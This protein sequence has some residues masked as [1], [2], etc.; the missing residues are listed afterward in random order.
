L[1]VFG[2]G[3]SVWAG[4]AGIWGHDGY[5]SVVVA[6]G[7][8]VIVVAAVFLALSLAAARMPRPRAAD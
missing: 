3:L 8:V 6:I 4:I 2:A 7:V 5:A 1:P